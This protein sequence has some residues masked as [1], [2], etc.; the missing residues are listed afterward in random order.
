MGDENGTD[1]ER[2]NRQ[3]KEPN[4][5]HSLGMVSNLKIVGTV[6]KPTGINQMHMTRVK[7]KISDP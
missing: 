2:R 7:L 6:H 5:K 1:T 4:Q 3:H